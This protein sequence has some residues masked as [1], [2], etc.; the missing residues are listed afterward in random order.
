VA[1]ALE[2]PDA[3]IA[4]GA[5]LAARGHGEALGRDGVRRIRDE[6]EGGIF[7]SR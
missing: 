7:V 4:A 6:A 3:V 1:A 5:A 2:F